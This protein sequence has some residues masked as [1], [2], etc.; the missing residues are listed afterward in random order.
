VLD[1]DHFAGLEAGLKEFGIWKVARWIHVDEEDCLDIILH[2]QMLRQM[3]PYKSRA[4]EDYDR[5]HRENIF[6]AMP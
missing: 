3:G 4:T 5:F 1:K 6:R 2:Q